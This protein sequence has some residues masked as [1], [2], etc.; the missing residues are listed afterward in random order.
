MLSH[1]SFVNSPAHME[2]LMINHGMIPNAVMQQHQQQLE[3]GMGVPRF[4]PAASRPG[5]EAARS[6][7]PPPSTAAFSPALPRVVGPPM[8]H[9][10]NGTVDL[11]SPIVTDIQA[12]DTL[13]MKTCQQVLE[14]CLFIYLLTSY[15]VCQICQMFFVIF[16]EVV[17]FI[18]VINLKF[19]FNQTLMKVTN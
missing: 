14:V 18:F 11:P 9:V 3:M 12:S 17:K 6:I 7:G 1:A 19:N 13:I 8:P 4:H 16:C 2:Y 5:P 10:G 15:Y